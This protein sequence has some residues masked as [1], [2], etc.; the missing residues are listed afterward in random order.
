M[1]KFFLNERFNKKIG[2]RFWA[3]IHLALFVALALCFFAGRKFFVNANLFDIL[4]DS[5]S[6]KE[7]SKA[8][9][10][11]TNKSGRQFFILAKAK[12]FESAKKAAS[13]LNEELQKAD[14]E[15]K[16]FA[17]LSFEAQENTLEEIL[18]YYYKNRFLLL[19]K[20]TIQ[21]INSQGGIEELKEEALQ[22]AFGAFSFEP[23]EFL[24]G[25]PFFLADLELQNLIDAL[26][27]T[28]MALALRDG[29]LAVE[30]EGENYVMLRGELT[31][32]GAGI[33]NKN[34]GVKIIYDCSKKV[35][36]SNDFGGEKVSFVYSGSPFHS[37]KSSSSAQRQVAIISLLSFMAVILLLLYVFRSVRPLLYSLGAIGLSAAFGLAAELLAFGQIHVLTFVFGTTLI[38]TCLDYSVHFWTRFYF[39][40]EARDGV[41]ARNKI[42]KGLTL[43]FASTEICYLTMLFA[44]FALLKQIS[45][46]CFAGILSAY[47]TSLLFYP[48]LKAAKKLDFPKS[49]NFLLSKNHGAL[50]L[51][52]RTLFILVPAV[53][54]LVLAILFKDNLR[55]DNDLRKFYTM[56][57]KLLEDEKI[58]AQVMKREASACYFIVK[59]KSADELLQAEEEF[60]SVL[61]KEAK[62]KNILS[63]TA[64]S[65]FVPSSKSKARSHEASQKLM[66]A[67]PDL[68]E[69]FGFEEKSYDQ[70][71]LEAKKL[72]S[73]SGTFGIDSLPSYLR[74]AL[75][76][77]WLGKIDQEY[78]SVIFLTGAKNFDDLKSLSSLTKGP[79]GQNVFF[80]NKM[81]DIA[82][83]LNRLTKIMLYLLGASFVILIMALAFFY[84]AKNLAKIAALPLFVLVCEAGMIAVLKIPLGFFSVTGI[85]LV[86]GLG[87]DY[88]I[89]TVE[90][91]GDKENDLALFISFLTTALS[92]GAIAF[93]SFMPVHVFGAV[94]FIGLVS[95]WAAA[96]IIK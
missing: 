55:L 14:F 48:K 45:V 76:S 56:S 41:D 29:V 77:L 81:S 57:G 11:L 89:Y 60:C 19:D 42:L 23:L 95:A 87:L 27:K 68:L 63:Y 90:N 2:P 25:D 8:D 83:E 93:S 51:F 79:E 58:S 61:E 28:G 86:F 49:A 9:K 21:K 80:V 5:S 64:T 13:L 17:S 67:A 54:F 84:K 74:K 34:S 22:K 50:T 6:L 92:F 59:A 82:F 10:L 72:I 31:E 52:S 32:K 26:S 3:G 70:D 43:S 78:F 12:S 36:E 37:Y 7:L 40:K 96:R 88:I 24:E 1:K 85:I 46:F 73:D 33:S 38:G 15:K 35:A 44:P 69:T 94:V 91:G 18:N 66:E 39:E 53:L 75:V 20:E 4:P 47:L 30:H 62:G 16:I 65:Q 71:F